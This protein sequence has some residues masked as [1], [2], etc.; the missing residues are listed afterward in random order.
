MY[1][2]QPKLVFD[3]CAPT[4]RTYLQIQ[5]GQD[6]NIQRI[7]LLGN[8]KMGCGLSAC[9]GHYIECAFDCIVNFGKF[10]YAHHPKDFFIVI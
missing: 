2:S 3:S 5:N 6:Q 7:F 10:G 1:S 8:A 4:S 9:M